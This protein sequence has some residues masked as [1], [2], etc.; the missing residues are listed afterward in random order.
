M[1]RISDALASALA[2]FAGLSLILMMIHVTLDVVFKYFFK[3]PIP[4]TAEVVAA[5]YMIG[6]VF[7]PLAYIEVHNRPIVVELFYDRLP[8]TLRP[9]LDILATALSIAF[10]AFLMWQSTKIALSALESGEYIDGLWKVVVWPS[11]F[12]I[13]LGLLAACAAL[14]LRLLMLLTGRKTSHGHAEPV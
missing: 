12:L 9:P 4:G 6:T 14:V 1:K 10:Y 7:L 8:A 5:Y 13:P 2:Y 11:R 3:L